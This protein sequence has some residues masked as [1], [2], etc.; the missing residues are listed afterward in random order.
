MEDQDR[1]E[2]AEIL[3]EAATEARA[4]SK[5]LPMWV[6]IALIAETAAII[7]LATFIVSLLTR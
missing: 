7:A 6:T 5:L 1:E 4:N 3:K 2:L